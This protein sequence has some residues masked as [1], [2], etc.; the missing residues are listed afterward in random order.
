MLLAR[1]L[2]EGGVSVLVVDPLQDLRHGAFSSAALPLEAVRHFQLPEQVQAAQ[3]RGWELHG[4]G[5]APYSWIA[6]HSLGAVLDFG[7]LRCWL[8]AQAQAAGA[9]LRLGWAVRQWQLSG[10]G[11]SASP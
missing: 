10:S 8:A 1:L 11:A 3:W 7:A 4:P 6:D 5:E 2:A 9:Q